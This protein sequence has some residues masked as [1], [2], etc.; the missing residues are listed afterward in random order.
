MNEKIIGIRAEFGNARFIIYNIRI[1]S[2]ERVSNN[3]SHGYYEVHFALRGCY[4]YVVDGKTYPLK[5][6]EFLVI[7]PRTNHESVDVTVENY[8]LIVLEF[9]MEETDLEP[10]LFDYFD[11]VIRSCALSPRRI[12]SVTVERLLNFKR[13]GES[14]SVLA[15]CEMQAEASRIIFELFNGMGGFAVGAAL[16]QKT[17]AFSGADINVVI[18]N[19]INYGYSL[20]EISDK[21][22]YSERHTARLIKDMYGESL[23]SIRKKRSLARDKD[24]D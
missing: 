9:K 19:L 10:K 14:D 5:Q 20:K 21:I 8:G 23:G 13:V 11:G 17:D 16:G 3:H 1:N 2:T 6:G 15:Y 12:S 7:P 4:D 24:S 18:D 22:N